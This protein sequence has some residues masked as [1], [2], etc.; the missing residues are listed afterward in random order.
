MTSVLTYMTA[1]IGAN[2]PSDDQTVRV[3]RRVANEL[4]AYD[5]EVKKV[6]GFFAP[7]LGESYVYETRTTQ[8]RIVASAVDS[9]VLTAKTPPARLGVLSI[10][11]GSM[12]SNRLQISVVV[13]LRAQLH[14]LVMAICELL[15]GQTPPP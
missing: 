12:E 1:Q 2:V 9:E 10:T 4:N 3:A 14:H 7:H 5:E 11:V 8:W 15:T 6:V 13:R